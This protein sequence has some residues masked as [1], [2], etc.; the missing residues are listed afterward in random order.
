MPT[1]LKIGEILPWRE[2]P[3]CLD[4][5]PSGARGSPGGLGGPLH[6]SLP[7]GLR[8]A[9]PRH[10]S[11]LALKGSRGL[12]SPATLHGPGPWG[13]R[14]LAPLWLPTASLPIVPLS[15]NLEI[16][17][18]DWPALTLYWALPGQPGGP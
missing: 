1:H 15:E 11:D 2:L 9:E 13:M 7:P 3:G 17:V 8:S 4:F 10:G 6:A 16:R 14:K 5:V 12:S 18:M